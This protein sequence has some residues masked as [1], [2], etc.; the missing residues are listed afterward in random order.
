MRRRRGKSLAAITRISGAL[1]GTPVTTPRAR[2]KRSAPGL[3]SVLAE[4]GDGSGDEFVVIGHRLRGISD[5][6][7]CGPN[8]GIETY[9]LRVRHDRR[10]RRLQMVTPVVSGLP[11]A[12]LQNKPSWL[13]LPCQF[14]NTAIEIFPYV[15]R[16]AFRSL[17]P[18]VRSGFVVLAPEG[19]VFKVCDRWWRAGNMIGWPI[20]VCQCGH[21]TVDLLKNF[22]NPAAELNA[23]VG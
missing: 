6:G 16:Q 15:R 21:D 22:E 3:V 17:V 8:C 18:G 1:N 12:R 5:V 19:S 20:F 10:P 14:R 13:S 4:T 2:V 11:L 9:E 23:Y 7:E